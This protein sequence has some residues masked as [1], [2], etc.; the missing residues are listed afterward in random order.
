MPRRP[1]TRETITPTSELLLSPLESFALAKA[2]SE[3]QLKDLRP[4]LNVGDGQAVDFTVGIR[5][6]INVAGDASATSTQKPAADQ[7]LAALLGCLTTRARAIAREHLK[8]LYSAWIAGGD[9]PEI[10]PSLIDAADDLLASCSRQVSTSKRGAISASLA[11]ERLGNR[12]QGTGHRA[13]N[14]KPR[15]KAA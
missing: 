2:V 3:R 10:E 12:E 14:K 9:A 6:A 8:H 4:R 15:R 13:Q 11:V 1:S 7:L 5:G